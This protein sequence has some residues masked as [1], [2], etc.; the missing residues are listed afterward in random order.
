MRTIGR[1]IRRQLHPEGGLPFA[2][3]LNML[4]LVRIEGDMRLLRVY[5]NLF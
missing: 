3:R 5:P 4:R 1:H 2:V